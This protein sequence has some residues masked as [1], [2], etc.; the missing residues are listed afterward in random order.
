[1]PRCASRAG[2]SSSWGGA[3]A[4]WFRRVGLGWQCSWAT[5][6]IV[7][8]SL[9]S[10]ARLSCRRAAFVRFLHAGGRAGRIFCGPL[11]RFLA[12]DAPVHLPPQSFGMLRL[13]RLLGARRTTSRTLKPGAPSTAGSRRPEERRAATADLARGRRPL[14]TCFSRAALRARYASAS[15]PDVPHAAHRLLS[16]ERARSTPRTTANPDGDTGQCCRQTIDPKIDR[17]VHALRGVKHPDGHNTPAS[18]TARRGGFTPNGSW[19]GH[20][21]SPSDDRSRW[22]NDPDGG[23]ESAS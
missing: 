7:V 10:P 11:P 2:A 22:K 21:M 16:I 18:T 17:P 15:R 19:S 20:P 14:P 1:M 3:G 12:T 8:W 9:A 13:I 6:P 23:A 5:P 4:P